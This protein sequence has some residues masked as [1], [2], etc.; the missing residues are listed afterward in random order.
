MDQHHQRIFIRQHLRLHV[1]DLRG[2]VGREVCNLQELDDQTEC[3]L[4]AAVDHQVLH[5]LRV[6]YLFELGLVLRRGQ[7]LL[8]E[9]EVVLAVGKAVFEHFLDLLVRDG[10][11]VVHPRFVLE[12]GLPVDSFELGQAR[13]CVRVVFG[14]VIGGLVVVG[15]VRTL[16]RLVILAILPLLGFVMLLIVIFMVIVMNMI[17]I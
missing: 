4:V 12:H 15:L 7:Y 11:V 16:G 1:Q 6:Q 17:S 9:L 13:K 14:L 10:F 3:V 5:D 8:L 2:Q